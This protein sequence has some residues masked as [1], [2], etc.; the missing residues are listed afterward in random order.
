M[1]ETIWMR[2][3]LE[4]GN[5]AEVIAFLK[6]MEAA[7]EEWATQQEPEDAGWDVARELNSSPALLEEVA[8]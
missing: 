5:V 2:E 7:Y 8:W 4:A 3:Q 6:G 1:N